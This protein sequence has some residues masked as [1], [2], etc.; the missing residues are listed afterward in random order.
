MAETAAQTAGK[1]RRMNLEMKRPAPA[2]K[3]AKSTAIATM[4]LRHPGVKVNRLQAALHELG[5]V[6]FDLHCFYAEKEG[7]Q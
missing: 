4:P 2:K 5:A 1:G 6:I 7:R 3:P